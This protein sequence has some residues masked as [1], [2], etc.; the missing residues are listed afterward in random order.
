M[1]VVMYFVEVVRVSWP[2]VKARFVDVWSRTIA[3]DRRELAAAMRRS[4]R[5]PM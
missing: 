4:M 2:L 1:A 3:A 5:G